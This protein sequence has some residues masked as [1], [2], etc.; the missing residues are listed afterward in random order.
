M[1]DK[2]MKIAFKEA[3]KAYDKDDVPVGAI[4]VKDNKIIARAHNNKEKVK[5]VTAHAE[6]LAI[7]KAC[8]NINDW[9]L[10]GCIMY[11]T[12]EPCDMCKAV[13]AESRI[14]KV[15][16]GTP[17]LKINNEKTSRVIFENASSNQFECKKIIT[18][19]FK[20]KRK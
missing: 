11:V 4:I 7:E 13:I 9:R 20:S 6:I 5:L 12:L 18:D 17:S 16:Y 10:N 15:F 14:E 2:Y 19:F 8:K 3:L 1:E